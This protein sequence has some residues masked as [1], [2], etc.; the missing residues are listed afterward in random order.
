MTLKTAGGQTVTATDTVT[1]SITGTSASITV[2]AAADGKA[3]LV[4]WNGAFYRG[5]PNNDPPPEL[6]DEGV[7][8]RF[9]GR[10]E[11]VGAELAERMNW[12][13]ALTADND[14]ITLFVAFNY[15]GRAEIV[16]NDQ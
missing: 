2:S 11:R 5:Y 13:E 8:M 7:R 16:G 6:N 1:G 9:V 10:R 15:G 12:A 3:S 4:E 14:R